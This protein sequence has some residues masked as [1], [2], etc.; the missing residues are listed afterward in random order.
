MRGERS[1][2][3]LAV[4]LSVIILNTGCSETVPP[5]YTD[6]AVENAVSEDQME[7]SVA[8]WGIDDA[9]SQKENDQFYNHLKERFNIELKPVAINWDDYAQK[10]ILWASMGE[11]PDIFSIDAIG[12]SYYRDW[13][14]RKLIK[15]LPDDLSSYPNLEKYLAEADIENLKVNGKLY[16]VPRR[17]YDS[18]KYCV[19]DRNIFYRWDLAKEAGINKE[20]ETWEEFSL[21]LDA[22]IKND[23]EKKSIQGLTLVNIKHISGLFWLYSNPAAASDGSGNDYKWIK[24]NG[25]FIPAVFSEKSLPSLINLRNMFKNGLIDRDA[26]S[27]K[28]TQGYEKFASGK[29]AAILMKGYG[30]LDTFVLKKWKEV[31]PDKELTECIKRARNFPAVDGNKYQCVF[32]T[33]WS[34]SYFSNE[35]NDEKMDRILCLYDYMLSDD[36]KEF[37]RFGVK[38]A[39][40]IKEGNRIIPVTSSAD[41][42]KK[43]H[44]GP[45]LSSLVEYDDQFQYDPNNHT[46]NLQIRMMASSDIVIDMAETM[47][48]EYEDRLTYLSTPSKDVFAI[49]D[50]EDMV[51][52]MLSEK[53]VEIIWEEIIR[54]YREK[55][56]DR[57]IDEVNEMVNNTE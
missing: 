45:V 23:P 7:I 38:D 1:I 47:I 19:H 35:V 2:R 57:V 44:S 24:E 6:S 54:G 56:L 5:E 21:M 31:Y 32:K 10:I 53:P 28:G 33:F 27:A 52:V 16:F 29:A 34:E 8:L 4:I 11:L 41:L 51:K 15:S 39:D 37:Y 46:L 12:T 17:L 26:I 43:Q 50:Y 3:I 42:K 22:I 36:T 25:K 20:P 13:I 14:K 40:Y 55:G 49:Y 48:P 18:I 9:L 30:N